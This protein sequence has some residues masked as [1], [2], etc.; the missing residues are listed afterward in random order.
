[1]KVFSLLRNK[2]NT[3]LR[4]IKNGEIH[5]IPYSIK[6]NLFRLKYNA[7]NDSGISVIDQ[8][9]DTL[10]V[11]DACR[12]D[13]FE[14]VYDN[15]FGGELRKIKSKGSH[16]E[17]W[18]EENFPGKYDDIVYISANPKTKISQIEGN[19]F[20]V[21]RLYKE[22]W[23]NNYNTVLPSMVTKK[24]IQIRE[25]YPNKRIIS[26][27][28]QPHA[29]YIGN[30]SLT[31]GQENGVIGCEKLFD[32]FRFGNGACKLKKLSHAYKTNLEEVLSEAA[33]I[34]NALDKD[35]III[36]SDHG[37]LFGEYGLWHHPINLHVPEL[38]DVP[39]FEIEGV[40]EGVSEVDFKLGSE[41]VDV[42]E[43][44]EEEEIK[45]KL[46]SL[47]YKT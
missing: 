42:E 21:Y 24:T 25:K 34:P 38:V 1:M 15:F 26:H 8:D 6:T 7:T 3:F 43:V 11:L 18:L 35:K 28:I 19:F 46:E 30:V 47:G 2:T 32:S 22:R 12:Y 14:A 13:Y 45:K 44:S 33:K 39:W 4:F 23:N 20:K 27:F 31:P 41:D 17:E 10:L 29:P 16:T 9:W 37:E 36:T 5:R 40:K